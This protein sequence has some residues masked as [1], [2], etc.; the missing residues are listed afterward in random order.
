MHSSASSYFPL[1][2][3]SEKIFHRIPVE[4]IKDHGRWSHCRDLEKQWGHCREGPSSKNTSSG[5][6]H[7][8][9]RQRITVL[10]NNAS[11]WATN[12]SITF[13]GVCSVF[14]I[15][16]IIRP[17]V[18]LKGIKTPVLTVTAE[19]SNIF[20]NLLGKTW[21]WEENG[22]FHSITIEISKASY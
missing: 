12:F 8:R 17:W 4:D 14:P 18:L 21:L 16:Y 3:P 5:L 15:L 9:D 20:C 13:T 19:K 22:N 10:E 7:L 11:V 2:S 6:E 1:P